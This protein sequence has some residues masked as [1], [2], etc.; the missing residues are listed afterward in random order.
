MRDENSE[1]GIQKAER[2]REEIYGIYI[3]VF[4]D[5]RDEIR[6]WDTEREGERERER[7]R[8]KGELE[9]DREEEEE[10]V[11]RNTELPSETG[12]VKT[13]WDLETYMYTPP[14]TQKE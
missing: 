5:R 14:H 8:G 11:K 6:E 7:G 2:N 3:H 10:M 4:R 1:N 12:Y 13:V 9:R